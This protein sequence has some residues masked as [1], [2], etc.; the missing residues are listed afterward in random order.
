MCANEG[1]EVKGSEGGEEGITKWLCDVCALHV[2]V[3]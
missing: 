3:A 1:G 2:E